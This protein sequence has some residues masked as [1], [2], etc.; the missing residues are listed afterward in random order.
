MIRTRV[1][2]CE[3]AEAVQVDFDPSVVKFTDLLEVFWAS[4]SPTS[5]VT[6]RLYQ[7]AVFYHGVRQKEAA[8]R[9][10]AKIQAANKQVV[11][12]TLE[13]V[14]FRLAKDSDQKYYLR[15]DQRLWKELSQ[16]YPTSK[17]IQES[18]AAAKINGYLTGNSYK[19]EFRA[20]AKSLG[21][22]AASQSYLEKKVPLQA[23]HWTPSCALPN[24]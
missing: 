4:H 10:L 17:G 21:L 16:H 8:E 3:G 7:N 14:N 22:S 13:P 1:G 24:F 6:D 19:E 15:N 2:F 18:A 23:K 5:E 9:S 20:F 12:S 11:T